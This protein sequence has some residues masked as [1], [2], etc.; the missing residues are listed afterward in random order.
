MT[1]K[2]IEGPDVQPERV[3]EFL[4]EA[5]ARNHTVTMV[6]ECEVEYEGRAA[7]DL[8]AGERV[9]LLKPDGTV[10]VHK[11]ERVKPVNWQPPGTNYEVDV[12]DDTAW[13]EAYRFNPDEIVVIALKTVYSATSKR[14][15]DTSELELTGTED[16]VV[17]K[18]IDDPSIIEEGFRIVD[19]EWETGAGPV[20]IYGKDEDG[21]PTFVEAKR[22][23]VSPAN[24]M[25]LRRYLNSIE[26]DYADSE[27]RG[28]LIGADISERGETVLNEEGFQFRS[29]KPDSAR[30]GKT[31]TT[32]DEFGE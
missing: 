3:E 15:E 24:V 18:V 8:A 11:A 17:E 14:L 1:V 6:A 16:D 27:M 5:K 12:A 31:T 28:F 26:E 7:S 4:R 20:D 13:I 30:R 23:T 32:L 25:Q 22:G 9:I 19:T 29:V 2:R 21:T 10:Q